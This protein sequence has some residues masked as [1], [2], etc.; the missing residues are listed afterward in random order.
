MELNHILKV[1]VFLYY[2][3]LIIIQMIPHGCD[4][5]SILLLIPFAINSADGPAEATLSSGEVDGRLTLDGH[6]VPLVRLLATPRV[7]LMRG[8]NL[9]LIQVLVVVD[10]CPVSRGRD[11]HVVV[12]NLQ[13]VAVSHEALSMKS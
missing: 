5:L 4:H 13:I 2:G 8:S 3:R 11:L 6:P 7:L 10:S 1:S 9:T 12:I